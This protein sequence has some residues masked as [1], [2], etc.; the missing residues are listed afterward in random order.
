MPFNYEPARTEPAD[1]VPISG[2]AKWLSDAAIYQW[3][4]D[5]GDV[6][7]PN[8]DLEKQLYEDSN[9]QRIGTAIQALSYEVTTEGP[10]KIHPIREVSS[11]VRTLFTLPAHYYAV[12]RCWPPSS[13]ARKRQALP[14]RSPY[15]HSVLLYT[16]SPDWSRCRRCRSNRYVIARRAT[17][18]H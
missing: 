5:F 10:E 4:D 9:I 7:E 16:C 17:R 1:N 18:P 15:A 3:D 2:E 13:H 6:G 12:R 11:A 8:P 14:V